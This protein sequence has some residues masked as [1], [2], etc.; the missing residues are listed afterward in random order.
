[1]GLE[2]LKNIEKHWKTLLLLLIYMILKQKPLGNIFNHI[3]NHVF[4][5]YFPLQ[6]PEAQNASK[7]IRKPV[8]ILTTVLTTGAKN[9]NHDFF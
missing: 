1:M 2:N 3:F 9:F 4:N 6:L 8:K 5:H 7:S